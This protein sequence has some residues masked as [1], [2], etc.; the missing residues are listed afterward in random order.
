VSRGVGCPR[1]GDRIVPDHHGVALLGGH[2]RTVRQC[3]RR[4][5]GPAYP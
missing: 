5:N 2:D 4:G 3:G 1:V